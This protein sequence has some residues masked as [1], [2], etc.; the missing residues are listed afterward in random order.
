L[1][2]G[3]SKTLLNHYKTMKC[4]S[5][6]HYILNFHNCENLNPHTEAM[7]VAG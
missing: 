3:A 7:P 4:H 6:V 1:T 5:T 2:W